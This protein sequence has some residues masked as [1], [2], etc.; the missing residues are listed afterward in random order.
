MYF[1]Q[2]NKFWH[3]WIFMASCSGKTPI[4]AEKMPLISLNASLLFVMVYK[5]NP[6][7]FFKGKNL[8]PKDYCVKF[9]KEWKWKWAKV[10]GIEWFFFH[11]SNKEFWGWVCLCN[12]WKMPVCT[13][14][15]T[16][17]LCIE[18]LWKVQERRLKALH[19]VWNGD[20]AQLNR[21]CYFHFSH[22]G[23]SNACCVIRKGGWGKKLQSNQE[24]GNDSASFSCPLFLPP[25][26]S[27]CSCNT[28]VSSP[29]SVAKHKIQAPDPWLLYFLQL[30]LSLWYIGLQVSLHRWLI[31]RWLSTKHW[32][33]KRGWTLV[34]V[35]YFLQKRLADGESIFIAVRLVVKP[36]WWKQQKARK[37]L[38]C[39]Q[40]LLTELHLK[41][42]LDSG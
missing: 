9:S 24:V 28:W 12:W 33:S 27:I 41:T 17:L 40:L 11:K 22:D 19:H 25:T 13:Y 37:I 39:I 42:H 3:S 29:G 32:F 8:D 21:W 6:V 4:F 10:Q 36:S 31:F 34:A 5:K 26:L 7:V 14:L 18:P 1:I 23:T 38:C 30:V 35:H 20:Q 16:Q 15:P 2:N